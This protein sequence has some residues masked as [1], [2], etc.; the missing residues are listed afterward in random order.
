M[1]KRKIFRILLVSLIFIS[2][3]PVSKEL[4]KWNFEDYKKLTYEYNQSMITNVEFLDD[5]Q[6]MMMT[7]NLIIKIKDEQHADVIF[8]DIKHYRMSQDSL[9]NYKATDTIEMPNQIL[10]QD[11]TPE[12]N[13]DGNIQ[14]SYLMLARTLFPITNRKMEI[15]E[16]IDLKMAM[17]FSMM[18]SNINVKGY[19]RVKYVDSNDGIEKLSSLIDV[20]E[21]TIPEEIEQDYICYLKGN[22]GFSFDSKRGVFNE[23]T[24][25]M[26]IAMGINI[27]DSTTAKKTA[28]MMMDMNTEIKIKLIKTE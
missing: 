1:L 15:G 7:A 11:L 9:G 10:F 22:S 20:S 13:I 12:G 16:T 17:P 24:I 18:G 5:P 4:I 19:N 27:T 21:Y 2:A 6:K 14:D 23:G 25:N 26:N 28:K 8:T 3:T